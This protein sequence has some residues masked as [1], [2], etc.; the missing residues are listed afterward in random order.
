MS[1]DSR[2]I[3]NKILKVAW[4]KNISLTK[5]QLIKLVYF[6]HGWSLSMLGSATV[7]D[8]PQAW[9]RGPVYPSL[10]NALSNYRS[11][12]V[13]QLLADKN[14]GIPFD[15]NLENDAQS[16]LI[17]DVTSSYGND[18]AFVLSE[19][20]HAAGTPWDVTIKNRGKYAEI[21]EHLMAQHFEHLR[22]SR[23]IDK[24]HYKS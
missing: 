8:R 5:M 10:Y 2:V 14:T 6:V 9:Q 21:D 12:P 13:N 22:E 23:G 19:K 17:S 18:H 20:T 24:N 11:E 1:F 7:K 16:R 3:A 15:D 4:E